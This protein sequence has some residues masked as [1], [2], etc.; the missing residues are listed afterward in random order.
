M[1]MSATQRAKKVKDLLRMADYL[2]RRGL[3]GAALEKRN[4]AEALRSK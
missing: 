1:A 3:W 2:D 4:L